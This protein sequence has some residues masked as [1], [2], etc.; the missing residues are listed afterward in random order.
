[1]TP[2]A[3]SY[4]PD[5]ASFLARARLQRFLPKLSELGIASVEDLNRMDESHLLKVLD[6]KI[7]YVC[8]IRATRGTYCMIVLSW[9]TIEG[10][11]LREKVLKE[12][13]A[14]G[15]S[16]VRHL[17]PESKAVLNEKLDEFV[18]NVV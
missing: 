17:S 2:M 16:P 18:R 14:T 12:Q 8:A 6:D 5:L 11:I 1:M 7:G 15:P 13:A 9:L 10:K 3:E 4:T